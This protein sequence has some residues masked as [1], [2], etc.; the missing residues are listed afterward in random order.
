MWHALSVMDRESHGKNKKSTA[1]GLY[2]FLADWWRNKK[3]GH[4]K[5][6]PFNPWKNIQHF[7]NAILGPSGW[8]PWALTA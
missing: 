4:R 1:S 6:N 7:V 5:W 3:T 2:Q 8:S